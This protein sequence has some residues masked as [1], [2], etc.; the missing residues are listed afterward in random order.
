MWQNHPPLLP[1]FRKAV[2]YISNYYFQ[3]HKIKGGNLP[4]PLLYSL[5]A[6]S[7][8]GVQWLQD[9]KEAI[10]KENLGIKEERQTWKLDYM[11]LKGAI[12]SL[13]P[14]KTLHFCLE[15]LT[16]SILEYLEKNKI[17]RK[18]RKPA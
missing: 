12:M 17:K 6:D 18:K 5:T 8:H 1:S 16:Y 13:L 11:N 15:S 3:L 4:A 10:I 9:L 2:F 7:C 14:F